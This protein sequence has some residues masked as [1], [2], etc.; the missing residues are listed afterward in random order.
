MHGESELP[1]TSRIAEIVGLMP[2]HDGAGDVA[3]W[4]SVERAWGLSFPNDFKAFVAAY[5]D[6]SVEN[7]LAVLVPEEAGGE[8]A[9][10]GRHH[11]RCP[12]QVGGDRP[13]TRFE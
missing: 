7:Y 2:P 6:G 5:G 10:G 8:P 4:T 11:G 13:A 12:C 1:N 3:D 9:G